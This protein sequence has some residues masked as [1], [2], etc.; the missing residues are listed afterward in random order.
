MSRSRN[1]RCHM[2]TTI[3]G[4]EAITA[5]TPD[6][7]T[8]TYLCRRVPRLPREWQGFEVVKEDGTVYRVSE[9]PAGVWSCTCP[10]AIYR[11]HACKHIRAVR[12][13][14][15]PDRPAGQANEQRRTHG[16]APGAGSDNRLVGK[17]GSDE[18]ARRA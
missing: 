10:D 14:F 2:P 5:E 17:G 11:K 16:H 15:A 1:E 6:G 12:R 18:S 9:T 4:M 7:E 13:E 3:Y 8:T